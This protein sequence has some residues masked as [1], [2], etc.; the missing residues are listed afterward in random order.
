[1]LVLPKQG[2]ENMAGGTESGKRRNKAPYW[3]R[4]EGGSRDWA[5]KMSQGLETMRKLG[6]HLT[7][8]RKFSGEGTPRASIA[9]EEGA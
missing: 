3:I 8:C 1:V 7:E 6:K 4:R 2:K 9:R 5:G